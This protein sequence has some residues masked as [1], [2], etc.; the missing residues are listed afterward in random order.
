MLVRIRFARGPKIQRKPRKNQ[1]MA[2]AVGSLL[3]PAAVMVMVLGLW[4]IAADLNWT[5]DFFISAGLLSHWQVWLVAAFALQVGARL[6]HR[7]GVSEEK[8]A[9]G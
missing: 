2:L 9:G 3:T 5:S 7:Y 4:R 6:L 8:G 1:K